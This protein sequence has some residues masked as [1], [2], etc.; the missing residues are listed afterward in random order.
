MDARMEVRENCPHLEDSFRT[1]SDYPNYYPNYFT[2]TA[3]RLF[4]LSL[5]LLFIF[6]RVSGS[7]GIHPSRMLPSMDDDLL[8]HKVEEFQHVTSQVST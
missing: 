6:I 8:Y 3:N 5:E 7:R 4:F 1:L 2:R